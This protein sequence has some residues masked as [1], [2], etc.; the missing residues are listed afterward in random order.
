MHAMHDVG[1]TGSC[2]KYSPTWRAACCGYVRA[3]G[4][5]W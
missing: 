1:W 5:S 4:E 3:P 2:R